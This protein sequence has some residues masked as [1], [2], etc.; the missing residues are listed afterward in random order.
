VLLEQKSLPRGTQLKEK[1]KTA[2]LPQSATKAFQ[3]HDTRLLHETKK[4]P[5][6]GKKRLARTCGLKRSM[7]RG[8]R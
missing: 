8:R 3:P 1:V 5:A 4:E 6:S 2:F 7:I